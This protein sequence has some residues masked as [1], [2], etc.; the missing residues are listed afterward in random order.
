MPIQHDGRKDRLSILWNSVQPPC[1]RCYMRGITCQYTSSRGAEEP[2]A[3]A[4]ESSDFGS[5][6]SLNAPNAF[7]PQLIQSTFDPDL[8]DSFF[9]D[10]GSWSSVQPLDL[11]LRSPQLLDSEGLASFDHRYG[12]ISDLAPPSQSQP[13]SDP[14]SVALANHSMELIF[15]VLRTWPRMLAE[16]FQLPP[17]FHSTHF[18]L[19][20]TLPRPLATCITLAKMWHG[21]CVGAEEIV[22]DTIL[23]ELDLIVDQEAKTKSE[24]LSETMLLTVIQAVVI[25]TIILLSPSESSQSPATNDDLVFR[26]VEHLV[27]HV[28]RGGLFLK[29]ERAQTR[30]CWEA[31]IHVTSKRR[32]VLSL[33]L[34]HWAYSVFHKVPCF[35]CRDLGFMPAPAPKMLWQAH[36]E[37][38][39]NTK[40]IHWLSRWSGQIYLQAE[41][42]DIPPGAALN[43]RAEK[44]LG[45]AD[46]F[47]FVMLSIV[48]ATDFD[49]PSLK[50]LPQ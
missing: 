15:R 35:D 28:V 11:S 10:L 36:T 17:I 6:P 7:Q 42:G 41:F 34:L 50:A 46:E 16:D 49:P 22:R 14:S 38:E 48:N 2:D 19:H 31:W 12:H 32:A 37:Q 39:W 44:W 18:A 25:Y 20:K 27:C 45:E 29:E 23:R 30:P 3:P 9:S 4:N 5:I 40:Y 13:S 21:Q 47:G 33:Y 8:F 1:S 43:P 26:K 24:E